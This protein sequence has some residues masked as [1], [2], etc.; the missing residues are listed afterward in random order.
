MKLTHANKTFGIINAGIFRKKIIETKHLLWSKGGIPA[1]DAGKW[2]IYQNFVEEIEIKTDKG[3]VFKI[4]KDDFEQHKEEINLG[5]GRQY[6]VSKEFWAI[7]PLSSG[8]DGGL[9]PN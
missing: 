4:S 7:T 2:D 9:F 3:R 1:L 8:K 6:V 5:W